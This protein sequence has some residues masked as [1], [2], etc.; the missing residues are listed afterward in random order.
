MTKTAMKKAPPKECLS[1]IDEESCSNNLK[2]KARLW[3]E[4]LVDQENFGL[5]GAPTN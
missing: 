5:A 1:I 3:P 2:E 4:G